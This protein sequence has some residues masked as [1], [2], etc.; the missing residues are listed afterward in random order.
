LGRRYGS[1]SEKPPQQLYN[2]IRPLARKKQLEMGRVTSARATPLTFR[3]CCMILDATTITTE[4]ELDA[5]LA[6]CG[7]ASTSASNT[8]G[9]IWAPWMW[10]WKCRTP[11]LARAL[12]GRSFAGFIVAIQ[13]GAFQV[14][15]LDQRND[16]YH[17]VGEI[18]GE[19]SEQELSEFFHN[20]T[21]DAPFLERSRRLREKYQRLTE[22]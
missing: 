11:P 22:H 17:L 2:G 21:M 13:H 15:E 12:A 14:F 6:R 16:W 9:W 4:D 20:A 18:Q 1:I 10:E 8:P 3:Q 19:V 7:F 5:A